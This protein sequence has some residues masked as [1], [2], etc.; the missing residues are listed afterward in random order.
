M[1][2]VTTPDARTV[3]EARQ[4]YF[5]QNGFGDGGYGD[6]W[7]KLEAGPVPIVFPN[8][9]ARVEA[10]RRHDLHHVATGF[11]TTWTGEAEIGGWEIGSGCGRFSAAWFL[12]LQAL[13]I[14][15]VLA[16][17]AVLRA[18]AW[19]RR[20]QNLYH[21]PW[22]EE[23]ILEESVD[24]LRTRLGL[25]GEAPEAAGADRIRLVGWCAL[26]VPVSL[27]PV[28]VLATLVAGVIRLLT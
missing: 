10:V 3:R 7:V 1:S 17:A 15:V 14:G 22:D 25:V 28:A 12:N 19:G 24:A 11:D 5:D 16:P 4:Q 18:F 20:S 8:T 13:L 27:F 2:G 21:L 23:A 6:R 26:A 9:A